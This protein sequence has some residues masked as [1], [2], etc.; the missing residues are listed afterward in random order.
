MALGYLDDS[1]L[2]AIASAIRSKTSKSATM[3][4]DEMPEEIESIT[5]GAQVEPLNVTAN[6][7]YSAPAGQGY[8]PVT[9]SVPQTGITADQVAERTISGTVAGNA[10]FVGP[11]A[12]YGCTQLSA[13]SFPSASY[14]HQNAFYSCSNLV[15]INF[16]VAGYIGSSAFTRCGSLSS[17]VLPSTRTLS[18]SAFAECSRITN[19]DLPALT[20]TLSSVFVSCSQLGSVSIPSISNIGTG[21]FRYCRAL[22]YVYAPKVKSIG[23]YAFQGCV[24][25]GELRLDN[26]DSVPTLGAS[27]FSST[28]SL[29]K[30]YVPASLYSAFL[31]AA[32]WSSISNRIV[33]VP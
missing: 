18:A 2:Y 20:D 5:T 21:T 10:A 19:I 3:T 7:T 30:V 22:A 11:Y 14:V 29:G 13:A 25:L 31:T 8:T 24:N 4:V 15:S 23:Q 1:K 28:Y 17:I 6:G 33:S 32:N 12:F 26:V 27:A 9:V 16:S